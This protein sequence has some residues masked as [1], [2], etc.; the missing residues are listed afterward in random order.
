MVV[1]GLLAIV[2]SNTFPCGAVET[3]SLLQ[4][5]SQ[6]S[7][8]D[9]FHNLKPISVDAL[10]VYNASTDQILVFSE[11]KTGSN[12]L[13][14]TLGQVVPAHERL[15]QIEADMFMEVY[16]PNIKTH[17]AAVAKDYLAKAPPGK[18]VWIFKSV[19]N[20]YA[21]AISY[22]F[23]QI[24][25]FGLNETCR[26]EMASDKLDVPKMERV[27][28]DFDYFLTHAFLYELQNRPFK[29]LVATPTVF[30]DVTGEDIF[31]TKFNSTKGSLVFQIARGASNVNIV[32]LRLEDV[33][34]WEAILQPMFPDFVMG[35]I[36]HGGTNR[37]SEKWY[38]DVYNKFVA[39]YN[40]SLDAVNTSKGDSSSLRHEDGDSRFYSDSEWASFEEDAK[41]GTIAAPSQ[42]K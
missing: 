31:Q 28:E 30:S 1:R 24:C 8:L 19:R 32:V 42:H 13:Q 36:N 37:A 18:N 21:R 3:S 2:A 40:F 20:T 14:D 6:G 22:Y 33:A 15:P 25:D 27:V 4:V 34:R 11:Q 26:K 9:A 16:P 7:N 38:I 39:R 29:T 12:T 17:F 23:Q 41:A 5:V 35:G 10:P